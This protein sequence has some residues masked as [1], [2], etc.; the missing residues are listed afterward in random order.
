M[1]YEKLPSM[2]LVSILFCICHCI[3]TYSISDSVSME[4]ILILMTSKD[5]MRK[6][7]FM[8]LISKPLS[9]VY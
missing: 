5:T 3:S 7:L 8:V 9:Y 1:S 4:Y 6:P 2:F